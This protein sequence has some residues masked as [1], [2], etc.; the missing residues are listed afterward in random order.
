MYDVL[1]Y[2]R[3]RTE[4]RYALKATRKCRIKDGSIDRLGEIFTGFDG[5]QKEMWAPILLRDYRGPYEETGRTPKN[6]PDEVY[7]GKFMVC[8]LNGCINLANLS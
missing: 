4:E 7:G 6:I 3:G 2:R 1:K 5:D 8:G